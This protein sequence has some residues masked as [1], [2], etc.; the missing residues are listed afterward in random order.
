MNLDN[1]EIDHLVWDNVEPVV[2]EESRRDGAARRHLVAVAKRRNI[3]GREKSPSGGAYQGFEVNWHLP[4]TE[5]PPGVVPIPGHVVE[6]RDGTRW[7]VLTATRN[8]HGQT[9][10]LGCVDLVL[11]HDLRDRLTIER[12]EVEYDR[13]GAAIKRWWPLHEDLAARVQPESSDVHDGHGVRGF[14][15]RF[16][17]IVDR[18][19]VVTNEDR[20]KVTLAGETRYLDVTGYQQAERIDELPVILAELRP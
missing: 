15:T 20:L 10:A 4:T 16:R 1:F 8:R 2:L 13:A 5:L 14:Q 18:D 3:R 6:D 7:T 12:P 11:A 19:L 9:H 17:V